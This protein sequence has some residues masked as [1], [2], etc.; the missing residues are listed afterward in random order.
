MRV[1]TPKLWGNQRAEWP[2]KRQQKRVGASDAGRTTAGAVAT[3]PKPQTNPPKSG[4]DTTAVHGKEK[5]DD[6]K[7]T[8]MTMRIG[9]PPSRMTVRGRMEERDTADR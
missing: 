4:V 3:G 7:K 1:T 8:W 2:C 5:G 6:E 9:R